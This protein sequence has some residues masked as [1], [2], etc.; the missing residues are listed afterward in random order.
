MERISSH[1]CAPLHPNYCIHPV[2]KWGQTIDLK[3]D[4]VPLLNMSI[5]ELK[6]EMKKV[7]KIFEN[8]PI[9]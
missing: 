8:N 5:N 3:S 1:L 7:T 6:V 9:E 4:P 2:Y